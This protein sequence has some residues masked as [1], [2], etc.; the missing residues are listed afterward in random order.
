MMVLW[1][2][3]IIKTGVITRKYS[4]RIVQDIKILKVNYS[5]GKLNIIAFLNCLASP[6]EI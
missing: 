4:P 5:V 6:N 3:G 2:A 1:F